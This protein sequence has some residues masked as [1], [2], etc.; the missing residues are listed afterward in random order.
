VLSAALVPAEAAYHAAVRVRA[1]AFDRGLLRS[2]AAPITTLAIGNL[3]VGG[4]GKTPISAWFAARFAAL[5]QRPAIVMRGYGS[6]EIQV[7]RALNPDVP[8]HVAADRVAGVRAAHEDGST[9]AVLDD[10]FQHRAIRADANLVLVAAEDG[11]ASP[12][13]LPR[14]PWREPLAA[15]ERANMV[16]VTRKAASSAT[17]DAVA[18]QL[19]D[20]YPGLP[21]AQASLILSGLAPYDSR[22]NTL[23]ELRSLSGFQ[24]RLALAGVAKPETVWAQLSEAGAVIEEYRAFPDHYRYSQRD[25]EKIRQHSGSGA[26]VATLKD[27]VKL[28]A[29]LRNDETVFVPVQEVSWE[30]GV[31]EVECLVAKL[32]GSQTRD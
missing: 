20:I 32:I 11:A 2:V 22:T 29:F 30:R 19:Y 1:W 8:I 26:I 12:R 18:G 9:V 6:D 28:S 7:H 3:T 15:L 4:T 25:V 21:Q 17:A 5:G 24:G 13:L 14:G 16:V 23:G 10:A 31:E 27:A